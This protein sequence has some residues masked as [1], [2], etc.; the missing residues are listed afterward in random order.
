MGLGFLCKETA[1]GRGIGQHPLVWG[2]EL[3]GLI[4]E[5]AESV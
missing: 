3:C 1:N 5:D 2:A 4:K